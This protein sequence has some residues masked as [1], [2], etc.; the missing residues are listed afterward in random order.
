VYLS[1][2]FG[3][4]VGGA[5][6]A[7][8]GTVSAMSVD[9]VTAVFGLNGSLAEAC[10]G[11]LD[12]AISID[13]AL[14]GLKQRYAAEFGVSAEFL[15]I[16]HAGH[17]AVASVQSADGARLITAGEVFASLQSLRSGASRSRAPIVVSARVY[18]VL[19]LPFDNVNWRQVPMADGEPP[20]RA[21]TFADGMAIATAIRG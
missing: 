6:Q 5:V 17:G 19:A 12:A 2:L 18:E 16:V 7:T 3:E 9:N 21:A 1:G 14:A 8:G 11:A 20:L 4:T 13:R 10:R 15:I